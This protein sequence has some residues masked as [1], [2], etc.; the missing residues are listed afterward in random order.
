VLTQNTS[1]NNVEKAIALM[2]SAG[3]LDPDIVVELPVSELEALIRPSG[4]FR[5]KTK[6]LKNMAVW[7]LANVRDSKLPDGRSTA[8]WRHRLLE[9][10]GI[11]PETADSILLYCFNQ[12]VFVIDAYTRR[13]AA[14]HFGSAPESSYQELQKIFMENLPGSTEI[15][16]EYHALLVRNAKECCRKNICLEDCPLREI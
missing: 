3:A 7:W 6:R 8:E 14:R 4:F 15:F 2:K 5:I 13:I 12:P 11:G 16:N 9:V 1:W 10:N